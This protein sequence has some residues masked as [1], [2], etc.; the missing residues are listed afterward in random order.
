MLRNTLE[1]DPDNA[2]VRKHKKLLNPMLIKYR[3]F[4]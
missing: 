4:L 3:I 1:L 2:G